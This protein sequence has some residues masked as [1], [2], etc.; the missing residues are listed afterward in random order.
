MDLSYPL[1]NKL[2]NSFSGS[3]QNSLI[4]GISIQNFSNIIKVKKFISYIEFY[5]GSRALYYFIKKSDPKVNIVSINHAN[6]ST[7][8]LFF[9]IKKNEFSNKLNS[10][11][12]PSPDTFL[13]QGYRYYN[14][15]K[16]IIPHKK[17]YLIGSLKINFLNEKLKQI[18]SK[19]KYYLF[20]Q[21]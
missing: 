4:K 15:I 10:F 2:Y 19:K 12:S 7:N 17:K 16:K 1:K 18:N 8:N 6:F 11:F 21:V 14:F 9:N 3:I 5:P 20:S 13:C